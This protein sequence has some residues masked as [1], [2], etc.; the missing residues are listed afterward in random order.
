MDGEGNE[1]PKIAR[2]G[3]HGPPDLSQK[4]YRRFLFV[5]ID[6]VKKTKIGERA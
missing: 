2:P 4:R 3:Q 1:A 5:A 6:G